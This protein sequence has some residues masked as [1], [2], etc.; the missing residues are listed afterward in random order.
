MSVYSM[1]VAIIPTAAARPLPPVSCSDRIGISLQPV[2]LLL[3]AQGTG[4]QSAFPK[5][6]DPGGQTHVAEE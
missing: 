4:P 3:R 5:A 2:P 6:A 1:Y